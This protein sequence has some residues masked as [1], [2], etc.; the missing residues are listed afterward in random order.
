[1]TLFS[2]SLILFLIMDPVGSV[3]PFMKY[4]EQLKARRQMFVIFREMVLALGLMVLFNFLG[5]WILQL[6]ELS[7]TAIHATSG[8][9]IFLVAMQILFPKEDRDPLIQPGE[10]PFLVPLA[11]PIIAG[12]ALLATIMLYSAIETNPW[13]TLAACLIAW[14]A[15]CLI[16]FCSRTIYRVLGSDGLTACEKLMGIVLVLIGIE[17]ILGAVTLFYDHVHKA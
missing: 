10:E 7:D 2:L 6:F 12:P 3:R 16:L 8:V 9:I 5:E 13:L 15:S 14:V 11:I 1:M 4:T 17:R